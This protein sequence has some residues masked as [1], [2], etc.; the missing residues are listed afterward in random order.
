MLPSSGKRLMSW[1][2]SFCSSPPMAKLWPLPSST[3]VSARRT[4]RA[5]M[6]MTL[7]VNPSGTE[8]APS[9]ESWLTSG[10][11]CRLIRSSPTK[12]GVKASETPN[13]L[14]STITLSSS[15]TRIGNSPPARKLAVSPETAVRFGSARMLISP[16]VSRASI[17]A[18]TS[19]FPVEP[20]TPTA[21][22][23]PPTLNGLTVENRKRSPSV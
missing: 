2:V 11:T 12:V 16:S 3:V 6:V 15:G 1:V 19:Q 4:V 10:R 8:I 17:T 18:F 7:L 9:L 5:G 20:P 21:V 13:F 14:N 22:P 23:T